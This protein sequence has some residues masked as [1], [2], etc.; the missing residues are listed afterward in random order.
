MIVYSETKEIFLQDI[1]NGYIKEKIHAGLVR[2]V[3]LNTSKKEQ[4]AWDNSLQYM[5]NIMQDADIPNDSGVAIEYKIPRTG[6]RIDFIITGVDENNRYSAIIIELKQWSEGVHLTNKDG[7]V[8]TDF[9][10]N[11]EVA[12]PCYQAWS[13]CSLIEDYNDDVRNKN[14]LLKPCAYLHNYPDDQIIN[15]PFYQPHIDKAPLFLKHDGS[16]LCNFIKKY[17]KKSDKGE[18][19]YTF[20]QG[21]MKPS[22]NLIDSLV[23][24]LKNKPEFTLIDSQKW[25]M[26]LL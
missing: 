2:E 5:S 17:I 23:S 24:M 26:K 7:V 21:K 11:R 16:E 14:I 20:E 9:Y 25:F 8:A 19:L 13:Y 18:V 3:G 12:H 6:K 10:G 1:L 15:H 4:L 22:K